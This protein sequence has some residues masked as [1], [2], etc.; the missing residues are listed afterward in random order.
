MQRHVV[1]EEEVEALAIAVAVRSN[2]TDTCP[3]G[4]GKRQPAI[5]LVV[6]FGFQQAA[7]TIVPGTHVVL[8]TDLRG[9]TG[10]LYQPGILGQL[11][12]AA[13]R[14]RKHPAV[15][16]VIQCHTGRKVPRTA[17]RHIFRPAGKLRF[18][19][20][21]R[22]VNGRKEA[23][24]Y[25]GAD[26]VAAVHTGRSEGVSILVV[27]EESFHARL[28]AESR[29]KTFSG[30]CLQVPLLLLLLP[31]VA[32]HGCSAYLSR[33]A[34]IGHSAKPLPTVGCPAAKRRVEVNII[35][36]QG[37]LSPLVSLVQGEVGAVVLG[38]NFQHRTVVGRI[39]CLRGGRIHP[40]RLL[41]VAPSAEDPVVKAQILVV[42]VDRNRPFRESTRTSA[43][44][45]YHRSIHSQLGDG[46][47][48]FR[49]KRQHGRQGFTIL[50]RR[51]ARSQIDPTEH[52]GRITAACRSVQTDRSVRIE[53]V[54]TVDVR[55]CLVA[56]A[57]AHQ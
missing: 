41:E 36:A 30:L 15:A 32:C 29:R 28:H 23:R 56:A 50:Q 35:L 52:K 22:I 27:P 55:L 10:L 17:S 37:K 49:L 45:S 26:A 54:H 18:E 6:T 46:A 31:A 20:L 44:S 51:T 42:K 57:S 39:T 4:L 21:P 24:P 11:R 47:V 33:I 19:R 25:S 38:I 1:E 48:V 34:R 2:L 40:V 12:V 9:R 3:V 16:I 5:V 53:H 7:I 43:P 14:S 13:R 8:Y